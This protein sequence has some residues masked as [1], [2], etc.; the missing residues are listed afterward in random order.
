MKT[1]NIKVKI[2]KEREVHANIEA[3][4]TLSALKKLFN[5]DKFKEF[6]TEQYKELSI[7]IKPI[8]VEKEDVLQTFEF[9][10]ED[11]RFMLRRNKF[12]RFIGEITM[13]Q[14]SNIEQIQWIDT[15]TALQAATALRKAGEFLNKIM[16]Q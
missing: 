16:R 3:G 11:S 1:Y 12:P 8:K 14:L 10:E 13:G 15:C 6:F 7:S 9:Y 5:I 4:N 2:S